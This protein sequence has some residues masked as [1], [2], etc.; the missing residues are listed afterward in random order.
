MKESS[1]KSDQSKTNRNDV[2]RQTSRQQ[3]QSALS[4]VTI[5]GSQS[6]TH[7][8]SLG[9][10]NYTIQSL[11]LFAGPPQCHLTEII[12]PNDPRANCPKMIE[13]KYAEIRDLVNRGTFRA[14]LRTE[15]P[16]GANL[17]TARYVLAIKSDE[18]KEE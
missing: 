9:Y 17:I 16:D 7:M 13:A 4:M 8:I 18:D 1:N 5:T 6:Q 14:V 15:L 11:T 3:T 12:K 10:L 2:L